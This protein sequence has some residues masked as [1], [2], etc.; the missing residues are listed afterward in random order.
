[1]SK[2]S[3]DDGSRGGGE[4]DLKEIDQATDT[5]SNISNK[6]LSTTQLLIYWI[7]DIWNHLISQDPLIWVT[8]IF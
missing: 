7:T 4:G 1:M 8:G 3:R 2:S 6:E 5:G